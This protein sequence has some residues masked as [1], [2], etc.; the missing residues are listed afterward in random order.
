MQRLLQQASGNARTHGSK[1][2]LMLSLALTPQSSTR[3]TRRNLPS[4]NA[5]HGK[6]L[7]TKPSPKQ[8]PPSN[9]VSSKLKLE[10]NQASTRPTKR[11]ASGNH[12]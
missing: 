11:S 12:G 2:L 8:T 3:S 5:N 9:P 1:T 10:L 6:R 7:S 4:A